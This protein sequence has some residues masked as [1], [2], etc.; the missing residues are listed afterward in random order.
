MLTERPD[1]IKVL[2]EETPSFHAI[3]PDAIMRCV[4]CL[5]RTEAEFL[6]EPFPHPYNAD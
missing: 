1:A 6:C 2:R 5:S 4:R 3:T